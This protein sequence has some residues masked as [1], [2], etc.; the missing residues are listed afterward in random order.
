MCLLLGHRKPKWTVYEISNT[1]LHEVYFGIAN[2]SLST[3]SR[4]GNAGARDGSLDFAKHRIRLVVL[5]SGLGK[6]MAF[7]TATGLQQVRDPASGCAPRAAPI[8][9]RMTTGP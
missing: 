2:E 3:S 4:H 7:A 1:D 9:L 8:P 6:A 5:R